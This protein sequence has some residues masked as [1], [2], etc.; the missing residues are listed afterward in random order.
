MHRR[1][2]QTPPP[3]P[4][5]MAPRKASMPVRSLPQADEYCLKLDVFAAL[6][7]NPASLLLRPAKPVS[8]VCAPAAALPPKPR[9]R[10]SKHT[11]PSK[12]NVTPPQNWS[13][14]FPDNIPPV[15]WNASK[16]C[17]CMQDRT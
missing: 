14:P 7:E 8:P 17:R 5:T 1:S 15:E 11:V 9:K 3:P 2:A 10:P 6:R 4:I 16:W 12:E 13:L